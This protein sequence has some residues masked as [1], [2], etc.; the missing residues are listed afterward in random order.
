ME[1]MEQKIL[2]IDKDQTS[3]EHLRGFLHPR[4][5]VTVAPMLQEA[6][7]Q[8]TEKPYDLV[9]GDFEIF[10]NFGDNLPDE[11]RKHQSQ[12]KIALLSGVDAEFYIDYLLVWQCFHVLP[13]LPFYNARDVLLFIENILD[14]MNAFGLPR[15]LSM[16]AEWSSKRITSRQDKNRSVE[17]IINFFAGCE[18]EIHE[19]YDVRLIMEEI[20][21]NAIFHAFVDKDA[22]PRYRSDYFDSLK[23]DEEVWLAFGSDAT[24]IGFSVTDNRGLLTPEIILRKLSRQYNREGLYDESGRGLYLARNLSGNMIFNIEKGRRTQIVTLFYEKRINIPTP[25]SI[26]YIE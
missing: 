18:Y 22:K 8:L 19:L 2:I 6:M 16:D 23:D 26:N 5:E 1:N 7:D 4:Y 11:I 13:K 17:E 3:N 9:L 24:T 25:L 10:Q 21:N 12:V 20:I 14:P 15:Y